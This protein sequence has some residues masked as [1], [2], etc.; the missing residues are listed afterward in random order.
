MKLITALAAVLTLSGCATCHEYPTT[1]AAVAGVVIVSLAISA[2]HHQGDRIEPSPLHRRMSP[3][4][5]LGVTP[6]GP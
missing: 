3:C 6:C 5:P 2:D 1:C 4:Q